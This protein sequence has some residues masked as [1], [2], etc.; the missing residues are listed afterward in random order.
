MHLD[1]YHGKLLSLLDNAIMTLIY[2][3]TNALLLFHLKLFNS[4]F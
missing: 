2:V 3:R 4:A 1:F